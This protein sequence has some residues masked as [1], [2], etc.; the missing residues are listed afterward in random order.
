MHDRKVVDVPGGGVHPAPPATVMGL[1][2][3]V[4]GYTNALLDVVNDLVIVLDSKLFVLNASP[5]FYNHFSTSRE[6]I[7]GKYLPHLKA[8]PFYDKQL[9]EK[10]TSLSS[11]DGY[12]SGLEV[13]CRFPPGGE[14][15]LAIRGRKLAT[16]GDDYLVILSILD[17]NAQ[18][19]EK[20]KFAENTRL[21]QERVKLAVESAEMGIWEMDP[22]TGKILCDARCRELFGLDRDQIH[23]KEFIELLHPDDRAHADETIS[24]V[25]NG[26]SGGR[27]NLE[28]RTRFVEEADTKWV[29]ANGRVYFDPDGNPVFFAGT[30]MDI[31]TQKLNERLLTESE[32]RFRLAADAA[33]VMI[34]LSDKDMQCNYFNQSWLRFTGRTLLEQ[35]GMGW[36]QCVHPDDR[37][38]CLSAYISHFKERSEFLVE[39]RLL[40]HDGQYRWTWDAGVPRF[41]PGG[42]FEGYVGTSVDIH[43][44]KMTKEVLENLVNSRTR[45]LR[46]AVQKLE[47][48]N[49]NLE[50]FAYV[51]SHDLQEP[52]RKIQTFSQRLQEKNGDHISGDTKLY[53]SKIIKASRRMSLL[54]GDLLS[55][56]KLQKTE[57]EPEEVSL[58]EVMGNLLSDLEL[59]I[60]EKKARVSVGDLPVIKAIPLAMNQ[61]FQNILSNALKFTREDTIPMVT[62]T[63]IT[64]PPEIRANY[65]SLEQA[66][67]YSMISITDNG[68]GFQKEFAEKIFNIFQRL[69]G[70]GEYEGTGIGLAICRK[71][72]ANHHGVIF[73]ESVENE[74]S[75]FSVILPVHLQT[76][77]RPG[78][79]APDQGKPAQ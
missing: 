42:I 49:H 58:N 24:K 4:P 79:S 36:L 69:N 17:L 74:G 5:A 71:I 21:L 6:A 11:G 73:A 50:E 1:P 15:Q 14:R 31:T 3:T 55:Y 20:N 44:Q 7:E 38:A 35:K 32:Q 54:I 40:R 57:L 72:V 60:H 30:V 78:G 52:L 56:S 46:D 39:Y 18:N 47:A 43:D 65:P 70:V 37:E 33:P 66:L 2:E 13:S 67:E 68:I 27:Y 22:G 10:L 61:L 48:S 53:L 63:A 62:I 19:R 64:L 23:Y 25:I 28:Y 16:G 29:K 34:W 59:I 8:C 75:T 9:A 51:A 12:F 45:L 26:E 77:G 76:S 41:S